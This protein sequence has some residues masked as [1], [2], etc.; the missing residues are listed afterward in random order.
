MADAG[1]PALPQPIRWLVTGAI[2]HAVV[3]LGAALV[4]QH[5]ID[6]AQQTTFDNWATD[7]V[8]VIGGLAWSFLNHKAQ[9]APAP[10]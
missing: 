2:R 4:T 7:T 9:T 1:L 8:L 5:L 10:S 6:G 3:G